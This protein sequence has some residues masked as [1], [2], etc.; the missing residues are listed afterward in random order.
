MDNNI[1][2]D[3]D[4]IVN[5]LQPYHQQPLDLP[6]MFFPDLLNPSEAKTLKN[7]VEEF[8]LPIIE[9]DVEG[10][11]PGLG[12]VF[13]QEL[14]PEHDYDSDED[15]NDDDHEEGLRGEVHE[16]LNEG[17]DDEEGEDRV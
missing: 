14:V 2:N 8:R 6:D 13:V 17:I 16:G 10:G 4:V 12:N 5:G 7:I 15:S 11:A 3:V 1:N 9:A